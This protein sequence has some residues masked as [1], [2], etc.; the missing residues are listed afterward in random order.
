MHPRKRRAR[1]VKLKNAGKLALANQLAIQTIENE[2]L[3]KSDFIK[4]E[5][6]NNGFQELADQ[7]KE[8]FIPV[9]KDLKPEPEEKSKKNNFKKKK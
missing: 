3:L 4:E 1:R 2:I 5:I 8:L 6:L 7:D 9:V